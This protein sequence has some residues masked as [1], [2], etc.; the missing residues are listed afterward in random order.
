MR[1][2]KTSI[3]KRL[4]LIITVLVLGISTL[5]L[6][7]NTLLLRPLYYATIKNA[8][9]G[10][11][12]SLAKIDYA[13]DE[14]TLRDAVGSLD[15]GNSYDIIIRNG[16][17]ILYSTSPEFGLQP[18]SDNGQIPPGIQSPANGASL[19][20][21]SDGFEGGA[22]ESGPSGSTGSPQQ[23]NTDGSEN[24][25]LPDTFQRGRAGFTEVKEGIYLG[26][27][28]EPR[29]GLDMMVCTSTLE[30]GVTV[31]VTQAVEPV[32]QSVQQA[33]ILLLACALLTLLISLAVVFKVSKSFTR[34]IRQIQNAVGE[35]AALNF[36]GHCDV[37][38][39]DELQSLGE[40]VNR[41]GT[42]LEN[43]LNALKSRNAQLEKD[44]AAQRSFISNASHELRTPLAL[45]K[46][47]ADEINTGYTSSEQQKDIYIEIIAEEAAKMSRLLKEMLDLTRMQSG[48]T[49]II[50]EK[51]SVKERLLS[52]IDKYD[53]FIAQNGLTVTLDAGEDQIGIF[54]AMRFEQVLANYVSNAARYGDSRKQVRIQTQ[55]LDEAIRISVFNTGSHLSDEMMENIWNSFYK[56]DDARTRVQD[57]YGLGLSVVKAI[58]S[59]LGQRFG[60]ENV[61]DGVVFWFEVKRFRE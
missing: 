5:I 24:G 4:F 60:A 18:R 51:L 7:S 36:E 26:T 22:A 20:Y 9:L 39:G 17:D 55:T 45:I 30:S 13:Q 6:L 52:F 32:N 53:G 43:A 35:L 19:P 1:T 33:N 16:E 41:L 48:R 12:D 31:I 15:V 8:M 58:Q 42:E 27:M 23:Q 37:Y 54:D 44:I 11:M 40:D 14:E 49:E 34:P 47:Y 56:A 57:S 25:N 38:T 50:S 28:R 21:G 2:H 61:E 3:T 10:A 46:G 59:V 29:S